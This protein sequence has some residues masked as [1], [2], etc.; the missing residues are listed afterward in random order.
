[1]ASVLVATLIL[2]VVSPLEVAGSRIVHSAQHHSLAQ[3]NETALAFHCPSLC[4][5]CEDGERTILVKRSK[6]ILK[7]VV[8]IGIAS[9]AAFN[10]LPGTTLFTGGVVALEKAFVHNLGDEC[11]NMEV[12]LLED[13]EVNKVP[14]DKLAALMSKD[15]YLSTFKKNLGRIYA[16]EQKEKGIRK[17]LW[18]W[19]KSWF[20]FTRPVGTMP[21]VISSYLDHADLFCGDHDAVAVSMKEKGVVEEGAIR[22]SLSW[23]PLIGRWVSF[24]EYCEDVAKRDA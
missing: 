17:G 18:D 3:A 24:G 10:P 7:T 19:T 11:P 8:D 12:Y 2:L 20:T 6:S 1:M 5:R 14:D 9:N 13:G 16:E 21:D 4:V 23:I 15:E 22:S